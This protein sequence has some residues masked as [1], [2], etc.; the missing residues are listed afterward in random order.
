[1]EFELEEGP[2]CGTF[3]RPDAWSYEYRMMRRA[4]MAHRPNHEPEIKSDRERGKKRNSQDI[5]SKRTAWDDWTICSRLWRI[6][7]ESWIRYSGLVR[8]RV[9]LANDEDRVAH[10]KKV[11]ANVTNTIFFLVLKLLLPLPLV[12]PV[13]SGLFIF[14][15]LSKFS[16]RKAMNASSSSRVF[17]NKSI[18][19]S[20]ATVNREPFTV[21]VFFFFVYYI[22][23]LLVSPSHSLIVFAFVNPN[24]KCVS[25]HST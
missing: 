6:I 11:E 18:F 21:F 12:S 19:S 10:K 13:T 20:F 9:D 7:C 25:L 15:I 2:V 1:M 16:A 3:N 5:K 23:A 14:Q 4:M 22:V 8:G 24:D 17:A